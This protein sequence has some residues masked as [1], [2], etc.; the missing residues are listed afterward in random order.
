[1]AYPLH[2]IYGACMDWSLKG[3]F[4]R[5]QSNLPISVSDLRF[6]LQTLTNFLFLISDAKPGQKQ[7]E[8]D[9]EKDFGKEGKEKCLFPECLLKS[10]SGNFAPYLIEIE[11]DAVNLTRKDGKSQPL[12]FNLNEVQCVNV[13]ITFRASS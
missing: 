6:P 10:K 12:R 7:S 3:A 2:F 9:G 13:P 4:Q 5:F 8:R 11:H 1:M